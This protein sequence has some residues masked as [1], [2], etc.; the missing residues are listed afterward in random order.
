MRGCVRVNSRGASKI[1]KWGK[2]FD[3]LSKTLESLAA[4]GIRLLYT[5]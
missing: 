1:A 5:N 3:Y 2:K 4:Q